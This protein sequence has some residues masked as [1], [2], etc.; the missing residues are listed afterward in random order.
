MHEYF[1]QIDPETI[2]EAETKTVR[3]RMRASRARKPPKDY[4]ARNIPTLPK[5]RCLGDWQ[6]TIRQRSEY[7][8]P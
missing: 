5:L 4:P 6:T 2:S 7:L 3:A 1:S 8:A